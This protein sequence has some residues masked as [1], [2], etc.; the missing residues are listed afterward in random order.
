MEL[1]H[2][3]LILTALQFLKNPLHHFTDINVSNIP[4]CLT[5][6]KVSKT[7]VSVVNVLD[8]V[9]ADEPIPMVVEAADIIVP[10]VLIVTKT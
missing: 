4:D 2:A 8:Y 9:V 1:V 7:F 5:H 10:N 3:N 6:P